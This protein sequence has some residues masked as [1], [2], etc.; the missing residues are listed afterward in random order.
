VNDTIRA[1]GSIPGI[2]EESQE[3]DNLITR[4][5]EVVR[6]FGWYLRKYIADTRAKGATPVVASLVPRNRWEN[7]VVTR[8]RESYA[9]WAAQVARAEGVAFLD[10]NEIVARE[11]ERLGP[12]AVGGL[13]VA[14]RTHTTLEGATRSARLVVGA[15]KGLPVNPVAAYLSPAAADV[16]PIPAP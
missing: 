4:K 6:S 9:G 1:R 2:G 11:Y 14:D 15:L 3:I 7:G 10:L 12:D 8:D 16:P 13:F 5:H